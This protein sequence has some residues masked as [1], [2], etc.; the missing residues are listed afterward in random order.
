MLLQSGR[1]REGESEGAG[2]EEGE[3]KTTTLASMKEPAPPLHGEGTCI[4]TGNSE[5]YER[6]H[7]NLGA[8][9][10]CI[11]LSSSRFLFERDTAATALLLNTYRILCVLF[12]LKS[13]YLTAPV[14]Y[15]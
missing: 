3:K 10:F 8:N 2:T 15:R 1:D 5:F 6:H 4:Y 12:I 14:P 11:F 9:V 13:A 7:T